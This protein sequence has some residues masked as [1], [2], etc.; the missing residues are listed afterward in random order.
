[1]GHF[2]L[3]EERRLFG[4]QGRN[5]SIYG[6]K[7]EGGHPFLPTWSIGHYFWREAETRGRS[8]IAQEVLLYPARIVS[9]LFIKK[10]QKWVG[11]WRGEERGSGRVRP[12]DLATLSEATA[13]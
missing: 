9:K 6:G 10:L 2:G 12:I 7:G 8:K 13:M 4:A 1:L 11:E 3:K 5:N